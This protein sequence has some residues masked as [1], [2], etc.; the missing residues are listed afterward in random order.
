MSHGGR[1]AQTVIYVCRTP[2]LALCVSMYMYM[3]VWVWPKLQMSPNVV[4]GE[5]G[6]GGKGGLCTLSP[7]PLLSAN[8]ITWEGV[9]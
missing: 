2:D 3:L 1:H 5:G 4:W 7:R 9:W 8:I 6:R